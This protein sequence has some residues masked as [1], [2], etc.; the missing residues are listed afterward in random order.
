M[1]LPHQH[2][3][4]PR[5][6]RNF[7]HIQTYGVPIRILDHGPTDADFDFPSDGSLVLDTATPKLWVRSQGT[8]IGVTVS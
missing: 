4:D 1:S 7:E 3:E 8:W 5:V 6:Q 2:V